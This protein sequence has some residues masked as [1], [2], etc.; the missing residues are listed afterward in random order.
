MTHGHEQWCGDCLRKWGVLCGGGQRG[1]NI[2]DCNSIIN[3]IILKGRKIKKTNVTD[4]TSCQ[5]ASDTKQELC[6]PD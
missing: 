6:H 3:Q 2:D 1:K 5:E 4:E